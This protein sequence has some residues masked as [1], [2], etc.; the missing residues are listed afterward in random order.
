VSQPGEHLEVAIDMNRAVLIDPT[1]DG[2]IHE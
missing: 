2:V 1:D